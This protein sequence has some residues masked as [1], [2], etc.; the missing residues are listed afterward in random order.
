[1]FI[2]PREI[3]REYKTA[4]EL[5]H[6]KLY[7]EE[8]AKTNFTNF[9]FFL[10][11]VSNQLDLQIIG[12]PCFSD[13]EEFLLHN[14]Y[15]FPSIH[16]ASGNLFNIS[17]DECV[18]DEVVEV[19]YFHEARANHMC[20]RNHEVLFNKL[21][22]YLDNKKDINLNTDFHKSFMTKELCIDKD[23]A[24]YEYLDP[25]KMCEVTKHNLFHRFIKRP[26]FP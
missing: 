5:F 16:F 26:N 9:L 3:K 20:R 6:K 15:K 25:N 24:N 4:F 22:N 21:L 12:L 23:F 10:E 17:K 7:R 11:Y 13:V 19:F 8:N 2:T 1:V 18:D 14:K